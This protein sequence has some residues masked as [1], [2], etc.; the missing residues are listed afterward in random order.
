M[1]REDKGGGGSAQ[2]GTQGQG[3]TPTDGDKYIMLLGST[4]TF[5]ERA[6][7]VVCR[8]FSFFI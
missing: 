6:V 8:F 5:V 1:E 4:G 3:F 7:G 2:G